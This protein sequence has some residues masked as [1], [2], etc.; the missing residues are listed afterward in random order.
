MSIKHGTL[1][2]PTGV[3][4]TGVLIHEKR[5]SEEETAVEVFDEVGA[6]ADGKGI[7]KKVTHVTSG[8]SLSTAALPT[9]G[10]GNATSTTPRVDKVEETEKSEGAAD[11]SVEDHYHTSGTGDY[12]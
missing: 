5:T 11:F 2:A 6:F 9:V 4:M 10:S 7:R 8:E 3:V 1:A 12:A